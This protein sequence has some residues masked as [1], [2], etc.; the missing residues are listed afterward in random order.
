MFEFVDVMF[1]IDGL[2]DVFELRVYAV[3]NLSCVVKFEL[4][5]LLCTLYASLLAKLC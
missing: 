2:V 5:V 3:L 1:E 4:V